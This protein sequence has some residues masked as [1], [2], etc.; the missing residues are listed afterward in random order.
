MRF[1][2]SFKVN[3]M[4]LKLLKFVVTDTQLGNR[5]ILKGVYFF[6]SVIIYSHFQLEISNSS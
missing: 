5:L 3:K 1:H 2:T 4:T 6:K